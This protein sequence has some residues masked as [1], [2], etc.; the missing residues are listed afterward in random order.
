MNAQPVNEADMSAILLEITVILFLLVVNGVFSMA[1]MALVAARKIRLERKA[2]DGNAGARAA[3]SLAASP[4]NFLSTVQIGTT[5]VG[6]MAGA[7]GGAGSRSGSPPGS[8]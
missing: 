4:S 7:F 3:L 2:E 6:V 8:R 1:E 5:L